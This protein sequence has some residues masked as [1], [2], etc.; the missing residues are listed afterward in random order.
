MLLGGIFRFFFL[1]KS[2]N[3]QTSANK[4]GSLADELLDIIER[5]K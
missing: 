4:I 5:R 3:D 1:R 2:K